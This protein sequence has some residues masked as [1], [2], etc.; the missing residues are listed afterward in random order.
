VAAIC[1]AKNDKRGGYTGGYR[2][3]TSTSQLTL[4][5]FMARHALPGPGSVITCIVQRHGPLGDTEI[6]KMVKLTQLAQIPGMKYGLAPATYT[7][8]PA[9]WTGRHLTPAQVKSIKI[10]SS[11][12][13]W[14]KPAAASPVEPMNLARTNIWRSFKEYCQQKEYLYIKQLDE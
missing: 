11:D 3:I 8:F 6:F 13:T 10:T 12:H 9:E 4:K 7:N 2:N 1:Y 5:E 14:N